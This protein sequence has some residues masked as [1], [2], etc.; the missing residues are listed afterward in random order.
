MSVLALVAAPAGFTAF[1]AIR[2]VAEVNL[3]AAYD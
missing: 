1:A 3:F 2:P